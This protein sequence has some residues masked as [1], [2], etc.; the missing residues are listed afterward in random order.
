MCAAQA[1]EQAIKYAAQ[2]LKL[3]AS[4]YTFTVEPE[5]IVQQY[6]INLAKQLYEG[7]LAGKNP[8]RLIGNMSLPESYQLMILRK[9]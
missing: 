6:D 3:D 7:A 9:N 2:W 1:I 4:K 8:S 5:F